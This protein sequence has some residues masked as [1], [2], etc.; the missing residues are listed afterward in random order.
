MCYTFSSRAF[1]TID[2]RG[3]DPSHLTD[4]LYTFSGCSHLTTVYA[5]PT[6]ALPSSGIS[7]S[8]Y[9]YSCSTSLVSGNG[10]VW[11]C[12]KTGYTY[13]RVDTESTPGHITV[14]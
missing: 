1:T 14:A 9:F 5:D 7:D 12:S 3:F 10:M 6:W 11:A 4:L 13:F 8:R 2:F